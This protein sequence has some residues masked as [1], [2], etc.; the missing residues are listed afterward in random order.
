VEPYD[1]LAFLSQFLSVFGHA[2]PTPAQGYL[3]TVF[4]DERV[5]QL[6]CERSS[7]GTSRVVV[8]NSE[9]VTK[10]GFYWLGESIVGKTIALKTAKPS[11]VQG[12]VAVDRTLLRSMSTELRILSEQSIHS[13]GNI[14][15]LLGICW[16]RAGENHD[17]VLPVFVYETTELGDLKAWLPENRDVTLGIQ[18]DLCLGI[19]RGVACLH[20]AGVAHCDIKPENILVFRQDDPECPFIPKIIDFNIA[21]LFQDVPDDD[22]PLLA[23]TSPWNSPEQMTRRSINKGDMPKVDVYSLGLLILN[24]LTID[25]SKR[26]LDVMAEEPVGGV[27]LLDLKQSGSLA[28]NAAKFLGFFGLVCGPK[29]DNR[30]FEQDAQSWLR[31][32]R[33]RGCWMRASLLVCGALDGDLRHRTSSASQM[34]DGLESIYAHAKGHDLLGYTNPD[35]YSEATSVED[36]F[37]L[38]IY[39]GKDLGEPPKPDSWR[40]EANPEGNRIGGATTS[41]DTKNQDG[42]EK[43]VPHVRGRDSRRTRHRNWAMAA[44]GAN[45]PAEG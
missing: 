23:G 16:Q 25:Y 27:S 40:L 24:I 8:V 26:I 44:A 45:Q 21:V 12:G 30:R 34:I 19:A 17:L 42:L 29:G 11:A 6:P 7:G 41:T 4:L 9:A 3:A 37:R 2:P 39:P 20:E 33:F 5:Y 35:L 13:H 38:T 43:P 32:N 36:R 31:E 14:I 10:R 15:T 28:M 1:L 22:A 18:L